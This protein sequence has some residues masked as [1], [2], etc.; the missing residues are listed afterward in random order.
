MAQSQANLARVRELEL[1]DGS[2]VTVRPVTPEDKGAIQEGFRRLSPTSRYRRFLSPM[3]E[4][5]NR[6]A[7]Y[8]TRIDHHDHEALIALA[9]DDHGVGV[10]RFVRS[11][12]D[13]HAAEMAVTVADDWQGRGLATGLLELLADR[14][15]EE[16]I[17]RFTAMMLAE[18]REM[19]EVM[20]GLGEVRVTGH[21]SGT[22]E[23]EM[24]LPES[25]VGAHLRELLR[26]TAAG[27]LLAVSFL[28]SQGRG[29]RG[30]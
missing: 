8:L 2:R 14:A 15:R 9:P 25:G 11:R 18:N 4:L 17:T 21:A 28:R 16:G 20:E 29:Q 30:Q 5:S 1:R 13:P 7:D 26:G 6:L 19:L 23:V 27:R 22:I 12:E 10:A 3:A 24:A